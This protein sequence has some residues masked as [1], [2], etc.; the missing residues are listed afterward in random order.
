[1]TPAA[2]PRP[3]GL[4]PLPAAM[5]RHI[6]AAGGPEQQSATTLQGEG[7]PA[8]RQLGDCAWPD[9]DARLLAVPLGSTE[10]HG[11]HLPLSADTDIAVA[12]ASCVPGAVV[13]PAL[14]YGS[15]GEHA[16]FPGTLSIGQA[17]LQLVLVELVR[18]AGFER[19]LLVNA[20]GGNAEPVRRAVATLRS[21]GRDVR[22]WGPRWDGDAHAGRTETSVLLALGR[23][24]GDARPVGATAP[25][26]ELMPALRAGGVAAVSPNGVLG[27][28]R[29]ASAEEGR[30]LLDAAA[31]DLLAFVAAWPPTPADHGVGAGIHAQRRSRNS[32][33]GEGEGGGG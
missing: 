19:V 21:E 28:A 11:P 30:A 20:H 13:A 22:A 10:Q 27:D 3:A 17:A 12:L 6:D 24:V 32:M 7:T 26:A 16:G 2:P 8:A 15:S 1:M 5:W 33:I 31:A 9:V 23:P 4:P 25:V 14:P 18:S 29:G